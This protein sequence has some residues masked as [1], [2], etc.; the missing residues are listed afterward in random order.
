MKR[1]YAQRGFDLEENYEVKEG[2]KYIKIIRNNSVSVFISKVDFK[3]FKKGD[4]LKPANW[5]T[6]ALN[7]ARGNVFDQGYPIN[8]TGAVYL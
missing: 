4:V 3:H 1:D 8:W 2:R 6:P 5:N 7:R